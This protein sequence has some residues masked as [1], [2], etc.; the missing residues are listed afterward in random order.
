MVELS[1]F[2]L[3]IVNYKVD[4]I[5]LQRHTCLCDIV[6]LK[7]SFGT[8]FY[9]YRSPSFLCHCPKVQLRKS[10]SCRDICGPEKTIFF[11]LDTNDVGGGFWVGEE[12][13][14]VNYSIRI[15]GKEG[16]VRVGVY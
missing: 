8:P 15:A 10:S 2:V 14:Q 7:Q 9:F 6:G 13:F 12:E 16:R 3:S 5:R 11:S 4:G 1:L